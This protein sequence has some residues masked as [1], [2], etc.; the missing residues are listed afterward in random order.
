MANPKQVFPPNVPL[1]PPEKG[2]ILRPHGALQ[3][4]HHQS[5]DVPRSIR[6]DRRLKEADS[7]LCPPFRMMRHPMSAL[8][9]SGNFGNVR[10]AMAQMLHASFEEVHAPFVD[11]SRPEGYT[12]LVDDDT[13]RSGKD[14]PV[15]TTKKQVEWRTNVYGL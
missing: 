8:L 12:H 15:D 11:P 3:V 14:G 1:T 13:D 5:R 10:S 6:E 4:F 7:P 9:F 2:Y